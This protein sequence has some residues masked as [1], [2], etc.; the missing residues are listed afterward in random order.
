MDAR[1]ANTAYFVG[2]GGS[3]FAFGFRFGVASEQNAGGR[4]RFW[5]SGSR[6]GLMDANGAID[7]GNDRLREALQHCAVVLA[8]GAGLSGKNFEQADHSFA[9]ANGNGEHGANA[10][11]ATTLR[12]HALVSLGIIAA[13]HSSGAHAFSRKA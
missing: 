9:E 12:I 11:G 13:Q 3:I 7:G 1:Q 6:G 5:R 8:K 10:Q 4:G 2:I